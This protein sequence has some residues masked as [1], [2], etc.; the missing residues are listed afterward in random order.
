MQ[1]QLYRPDL[2][3]VKVV[4]PLA[5]QMAEIMG[6]FKRTQISDLTHLWKFE[7]VSIL[8]K[9]TQNTLI[10]KR[11]IKQSSFRAICCGKRGSDFKR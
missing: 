5:Q 7:G 6:K 10:L 4:Q 9:E 8:P 11:N 3:M 2:L 1:V